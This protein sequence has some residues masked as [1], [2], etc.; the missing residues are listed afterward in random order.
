MPKRTRSQKILHRL[1]RHT[2][3]RNRVSAVTRP[4]SVR[5]WRGLDPLEPRLLLAA[6]P[7]FDLS[8]LLPANGGDG[9]A[10]IVINGIDAGDDSGYSVSSAGDVNGDGFD[11]LI[12]GAP[13]ADPGGDS[14]AGESYVVFGKAGGFAALLDL[15]ALDG[16]NGFRL[17]GID[18]SDYSGDS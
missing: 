11:D 6:A 7:V 10:G 18:A 3:S 13:Y 16:S 15:S 2:V 4:E 1:W 14:M 17:D 12:I 5:R 9:S 8:D